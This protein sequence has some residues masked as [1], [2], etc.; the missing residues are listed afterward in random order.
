MIISSSHRFITNCKSLTHH[1]ELWALCLG[2]MALFSRHTHWYIFIYKAIFGLFPVILWSHVTT[3]EVQKWFVCVCE[4]KGMS[5]LHFM[6]RH[7]PTFRHPT[8]WCQGPRDVPYQEFT[9][10]TFSS[11]LTWSS[12]CYKWQI[13][14]GGVHCQDGVMW[15]DPCIHGP[16]H[17]G[18]CIPV[19][20]EIFP[21]PVG[22]FPEWETGLQSH[23][24]LQTIPNDKHQPPIWWLTPLDTKDKLFVFRNMWDKWTQHLPLLFNPDVD[25]CVDEQ[26]VPFKGRCKSRL[27]MPSKGV[28]NLGHCRC[29]HI[30]CLEVPG[31]Y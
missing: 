29:H 20:R 8:T 10:L 19:Q 1:C 14:M 23:Y 7:C 24:V 9:I 13:Y 28:K 3:R 22:R 27:Y 21:Q 2:R 26:L 16:S 11:L 31:I 5:G 17:P 15:I 18:Q 12:W 4:K 30:I 25:I 6:P